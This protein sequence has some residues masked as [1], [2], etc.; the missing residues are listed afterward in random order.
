[1]ITRAWTEATFPP[2]LPTT[3][4]MAGALTDESLD[5]PAALKWIA[6]QSEAD[7]F[8][9][10]AWKNPPEGGMHFETAWSVRVL[11]LLGFKGEGMYLTA[12]GYPLGTTTFYVRLECGRFF[13]AFGP[14]PELAAYRGLIMF[15]LLRRWRDTAPET[16]GSA[17]VAIARGVAELREAA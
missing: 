12:E 7:Q 10:P 16:R 8:P 9:S 13:H 1:M 17:E 14:T 4:C 5:L 11:T 3:V 15:A 6:A 2:D